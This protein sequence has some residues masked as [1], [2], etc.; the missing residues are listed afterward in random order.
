[1]LVFD[2]DEL[3]GD[4]QFEVFHDTTAPLFTTTPLVTVDRF[5]AGAV[6]HLVDDL[7]V[8]SV[9]FGEQ[10]L[11]R[12]ARH[13]A[14][15]DTDW[16]G[17]VVPHRGRLSGSCGRTTRIDAR[18][19]SVTLVDFAV[20]FSLRSE[21]AEVVMASLPRER[22][23]GLDRL[24]AEG[25]AV[26]LSSDEPEGGAVAATVAELWARLPGLSATEA[27]V[28]ADQLSEVVGGALVDERPGAPGAPVSL[29]SM[30]GFLHANLDD[31]DLGIDAL[32][33]TFHCSRSSIYR[34][35][36]PEGGVARFIREQRLHRCYRELT[37][38]TA[39]PRRVSEVAVRWGFEN[40]SHFNRL[41]KAAFGVAP[42]EVVR[43]AR[44][45]TAGRPRFD[46]P[47]DQLIDRFH[48]WAIDP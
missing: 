38:P 30:K 40:P 12:T 5:R 29:S 45:S 10:E 39:L 14:P 46:R 8:S 4:E 17:L 41:F 20:P 11:R 34:L 32:R 44:T 25:G 42:T 19:G 48:D 1:M 37:A 16:V 23:S 47:T 24:T 36:E 21:A 27:S 3:P 31:L 28:F 22:L 26:T 6:D 7:V 13:V 2:D 35:F 9:R 18:P 15:G 33:S 43:Q